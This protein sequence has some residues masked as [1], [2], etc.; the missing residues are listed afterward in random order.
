MRSH[1]LLQCAVWSYVTC[2]F[3][4]FLFLVAVLFVCLVFGL[5]CCVSCLVVF[6]GSLHCDGLLD[7]VLVHGAI[8]MP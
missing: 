5:F 4:L 1:F 7:C 2:N 6:S 3:F 8:I